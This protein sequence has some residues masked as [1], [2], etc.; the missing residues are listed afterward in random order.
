[1]VFELDAGVFSEP[2]GAYFTNTSTSSGSTTLTYTG[3]L[4]SGGKQY[5]Y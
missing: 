4:Q 3:T 5:Y 1:V 2:Q